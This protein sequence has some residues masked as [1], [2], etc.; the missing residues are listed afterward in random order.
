MEIFQVNM[1]KKKHGQALVAVKLAGLKDISLRIL[2]D[3]HHIFLSLFRILNRILIKGEL[4]G[5]LSLG[6]PTNGLSSQTICSHV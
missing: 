1:R 5:G 2:G 3:K 4:Q 6:Q